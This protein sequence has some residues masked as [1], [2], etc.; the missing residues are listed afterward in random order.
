MLP[1]I[2]I[3]G[4]PN[5]GKS[6]L[7]NCL[8]SSRS[9]LVADEPGVTRD[10]QYGQGIFQQQAF[11]AIDTG[12]IGEDNQE[13][14]ILT[15]QQTQQAI[16]EADHILF[17]VDGK[18][19][20]T[21]AD[22]IIAKQLRP[23][24]KKI[25]LVVN[26][27]DNKQEELNT[28]DFYALGFGEP[29]PIA[30]TH[31][32]GL[33]QLLTSVFKHIPAAEIESV[34]EDNSIKIAIVG[35]PNVGKSTLVNRM[36]GEDRVIVFD[37]PGTTRDSIYV[38]FER[39]GNRYT[40]IDTAGVRR[41]RSID[42]HV[43]KIS[44]VKSLQSVSDTNVVI[45]VI[46]ARTGITEQDLHLL[47][48]II[49]SGKALVI[50]INK[51][52][53]LSH[54]QRERVRSELDR[55]LRFI[56]FAKIHM[57]SALHGTGVGDL[58]KYV[59]QAYRSATKKL[60]TPQLSRILE[61]AVLDHQPPLVHG[62]RVKLRFAH[63][64]GQNPPIIVIHGNQLLALPNSY[65]RY[66]ESTFRQ[67]LRLIGTPVRIEFKESE[68]PFAGKKNPLTDSQMRK[69]QRLIKHRKRQERKK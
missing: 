39:M 51:W 4:R 44:V 36:L 66:L 31:K 48:F 62:R 34:T 56:D 6:T 63:A 25:I 10:R 60:S 17:V 26:K 30:A 12:G 49:D 57:I 67:A 40:L 46:D 7:F 9:A 8:T 29:Q 58:W 11:I 32:I 1:V 16:T 33:D 19:G 61:Q 3:V 45:M 37:Q 24:A 13:I 28:T 21:A 69:R 42:E 59:N 50:A 64:G 22:E 23:L 14:N 41:K 5:V 47:G 35:K 68:N 15:A 55:R 65:K 27:I 20:R 52:D 38:P 18:T 53:H 43:E 54:S 2:A